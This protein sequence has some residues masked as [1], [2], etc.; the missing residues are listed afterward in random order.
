[1]KI[2]IITQ[3]VDLNNPVLGFFH[4][5]I[6][7]FS[8]KFE[9]VTVI[10]LEKGEYNLP[11]NTKVLSLGKGIKK[12]RMMYL[13]NFYKYIWQERK[14]YDA[15]FVHMN[16]EYVL[17]GWKIWLLLGKK[18]YMWR[19]HPSGSVLTGIA[20]MFCK[21]I[22]CTSRFSYT[23]KYKKTVIMPV[24]IDTNLFKPDSA[25]SRIK[26]SILFLGRIAPVK[27]L[28]LLIDT[29]SKITDIP[30]TLTVVG[31]PLSKD[32]LYY[33]SLKEKCLPLGI[34][35]KV[36]FQKGLQNNQTPNIYSANEIFINLSPS[37]MYDKTIFEAMLC[38]CVVLTSNE[39]LSGKID[40]RLILNQKNSLEISIKIKNALSLSDEEKEK[41][42]SENKKFAEIQS[43]V[44][45]GDKLY[46]E[47]NI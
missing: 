9:F 2:L 33:K 14:N 4:R 38:G 16:Q 30:W 25:I 11:L 26:N 35:S 32:E 12:S 36:N 28:G 37:G 5:W 8:K 20:S 3:S 6:E 13:W 47:M 1:M 39:N 21:K 45:L 41:I 7:E 18:I 46:K 44:M 23:A 34:E 24:G 27:N 42:I 40:E 19:N 31:N 22:F 17:L 43:L 15:V 10:C 29:V